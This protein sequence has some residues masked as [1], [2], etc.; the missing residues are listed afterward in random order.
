LVTSNTAGVKKT[1][2]RELTSARHPLL[3][4]LRAALRQGKLT[5]D[6]CCAVEG[7]HLVEEALASSLEIAALIGS[8]SGLKVLEQFE[9]AT[10]HTVPSYLVPER[11]FRSLADTQAPQGIAA[12]VRLG[13]HRIEQ[14]L[15]N[16][17]GVVAV[18]VGLQ[19][20]GNLG[21]I[22]RALEA[23]GGTACLLARETVSPFNA[24]AVRA[25]AGALF[26]IP[27]FEGLE[28]ERI[29]EVCRTHGL[30]TV[31]LAPRAPT[32]L[33]Q[34]DLTVPVALFVGAEARGLPA[35]LASR[36]DVVAQIPLGR[37][38]ESLNA[39]MAASVAFYET[40]RQR[41]WRA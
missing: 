24:K 3:K 22:L 11:V 38:V 4:S 19:D 27:V 14:A 23:F 32:M 26:R 29:L 40:A 33:N 21:T 1:V 30:Q 13:D 39:A 17:K 31:G 20:P 6:G 15:A 25:S 5:A 28:I 35:A 34:A 12:L 10:S 41:G 37:S 18:L 2:R 9:A 36:L 7:F 16:P 8:R